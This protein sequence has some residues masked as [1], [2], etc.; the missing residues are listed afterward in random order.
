[1]ASTFPINVPLDLKLNELRNAI[2][3]VLAS[4]PTGV[5]GLSYFDSTLLSHYGYN[6]AEW[7]PF[8]ARKA[9]NIPNSALATNPLNRANHTGTQLASTISDLA[10]TVQAYPLSS[11]AVPTGPVAFNSQRATGLADPT[12][13]Q[14][15]ATKNYVDTAVQ[16][17]AAGIDP[18]EAVNAATT[19]NITLSGTQTVDGVTLAVGDRVLVKNQ[20]N[21][22]QNGIYRVA[23]STWSRAPDATQGNLTSGA[24]VLVLG[25]TN[26]AGSQWFLNTADPIT[27]GTT[28]QSWVQFGAGGAYAAGDGLI[29]TGNT[30]KVGAGTGIVVSAGQTAI[31]T[32]VVARKF[33]T[34]LDSSATSYTVTHG[35]GTLDV[36]VTVRNLSTGDIEYAGIAAA[37]VNTVTVQFASAPA[38]NAY[39]VTVVG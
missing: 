24:M 11:F 2:T 30:F 1:M 26:N 23:N 13:A 29:L 16:S 20:T 27:V 12:S 21:A 17:A 36:Q 37:T 7:Y 8:D 6:G 25:G 38:A 39:R 34:T 5:L 14:D 10:A 31:D 19:A 9:T 15:A 3:Q 33:S 35:L 28:A 18:K 22:A 4:A 32:D